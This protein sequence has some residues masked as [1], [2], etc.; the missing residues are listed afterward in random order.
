[1]CCRMLIYWSRLFELPLKLP[2]GPRNIGKFK[3]RDNECHSISFPSQSTLQTLREQKLVPLTWNAY[4]IIYMTS[5]N[6]GSGCWGPDE[7]VQ[8]MLGTRCYLSST[9]LVKHSTA[10]QLTEALMHRPAHALYLQWQCNPF[11]LFRMVGPSSN[12]PHYRK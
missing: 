3:G 7:A 11:C 5:I 4:N 10:H 2:S 9:N 12:G 8:K 6:R 1:M